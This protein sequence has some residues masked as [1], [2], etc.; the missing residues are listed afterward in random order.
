[1][2]SHGDESVFLSLTSA[3]SLAFILLGS[4]RLWA[5]RHEKIKVEPNWLVVTKSVCASSSRATRSSL[6]L[7]QR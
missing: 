4:Y 1:M 2:A 5:L 6:L 7:L 3:I